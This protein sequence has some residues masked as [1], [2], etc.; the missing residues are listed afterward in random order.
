VDERLLDLLRH[1]GTRS[2]SEI[3]GTLDV[4]E[5]TVRRSLRR[6]SG[7]GRVIRTY[8]GAVLAGERPADSPAESRP[9]D[10]AKREIGAAAA[11]LVPD[12]ATVVLSSGS[13]VLAL[14]R[15][16]RGRRLTVITNAIDVVSAVADEPE[17]EVVVLGGILLPR[18]RSLIGHLT[19]R[20]TRD[21]RADVVFMGAS[22]VDLEHGFMTEEV[23]EI[24][25]DRA[26]R[27]IARDCVILADA[28][29]FDRVAPGFMF[30][31][32]QVGTLVTDERLR[33]AMRTALG[34]RGLTVVVAPSVDLSTETAGAHGTEPYREPGP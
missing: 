17:I 22:A 29:K 7:S 32:D 10:Q 25:T 8:G 20:A 1:R 3:A 30:G 19:D 4:G 33:P 14:A 28:S 6:L 21:L 24:Q 2:V 13:T 18:S 15:L 11:G 31:F 26:M 23:G 12:G 27:G 5:A 9:D 16:L 34:E